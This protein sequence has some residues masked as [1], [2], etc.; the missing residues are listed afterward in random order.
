M[1]I[2]TLSSPERPLAAIRVPL[3]IA[4]GPPPTA[5]GQ[6]TPP[7]QN[8]N[9][10]A[11]ALSVTSVA[12]NVQVGF[13]TVSVRE[14]GGGRIGPVNGDF[15]GINP[16]GDWSPMHSCPVSGGIT[17]DVVVS[18]VTGALVTA[19]LYFFLRR[20]GPYCN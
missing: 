10:I 6:L 11:V 19:D 5:A 13:M 12:P 18:Q 2:L 9:V 16:N 20:N 17:Y 4:A 3:T 15:V 14:Q 8:W 1:I 7:S